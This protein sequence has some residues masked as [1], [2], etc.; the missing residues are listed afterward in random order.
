MPVPSASTAPNQFYLSLP[1]K[2]MGAGI[3][4]INDQNKIIVVKPTYKPHW[5]IPGGVVEKDESPLGGAV[6][7]VGEEL[8]LTISPDRVTFASLDYIAAGGEKTE[9]LMFLFA[10]RVSD[11]LIAKIRLDR[12]EV[13]EFKLIDPS[14]ATAFLG[15]MLGT[16]VQRGVAAFLG[17]GVAYFEGA[18]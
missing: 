5:E 6:R 12:R 2:R 11:E 4:L 15:D 8:G 10:T 7:E 13:S 9:A 1:A 18:Y 17:G 16:R 3:I 14:D